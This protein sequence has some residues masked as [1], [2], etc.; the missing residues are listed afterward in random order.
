MHRRGIHDVRHD[1]DRVLSAEA[2]DIVKDVGERVLVAPGQDEP[3]ATF[4]EAA[5]RLAADAR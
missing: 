3:G 5:G 2:P 4:G 1:G